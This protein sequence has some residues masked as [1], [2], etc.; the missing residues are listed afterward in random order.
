MTMQ[1]PSPAHRLLTLAALLAALPAA[2]A[3]NKITEIEDNGRR[4]RHTSRRLV[5]H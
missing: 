4:T 3:P 5:G 2:A 1:K